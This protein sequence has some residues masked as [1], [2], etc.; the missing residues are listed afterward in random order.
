M[1]VDILIVSFLHDLPYLV[2]NLRS[3]Q[4]FATGFGDVVVVVPESE[5]EGFWEVPQ[6]GAKLLTYKRTEDTRKW[7]IHAQAQK[8][9]ADKHC[10]TADFILH[11]DSDCLF[12][13]PVSPAD[14]FEDGLPV[15]LM[16]SY[17]L[18]PAYFPWQAIVK[19]AFGYDPI[20]EFMQRHPQVNPRALYPA[21]RQ[22]FEEKNG[23]DFEQWVLTLRPD[24]PWGIT[25]HN[26]LGAFAYWTREFHEQYRWID[27]ATEPHPI[28]SRKLLQFWSRQ[29]PN[30]PQETPWGNKLTP[31]E[32]FERLGV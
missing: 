15:M 31:R 7:H 6:L 10:P 30:K 11:T 1:K 22:M 9:L 5:V 12:V 25:E 8:C 17:A 14:Y 16:K 21:M 27:L 28:S 19:N 20:Y 32:V 4:K 24:Y 23:M 2:H 26:F 13:E 3:I 29:D 18:L